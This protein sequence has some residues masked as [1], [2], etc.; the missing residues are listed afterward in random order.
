MFLSYSYDTG[1]IV[2]KQLLT[3]KLDFVFKKLFATNP[4]LLID[5]LNTVLELPDNRQI[6]A[7][8][9]K[10]PTIL[11]EHI[12]EKFIILDILA[13]DDRYRQYDI[14]MQSQKYDAY[15]QRMLFYLAKLYAG[16]LDSGE[17]YD[18]LL[19]VIGVHFLNFAQFSHVDDFHFHFE[20]KDVHHPAL[21]LTGDLALYLFELPKLE[22]MIKTAQWGE[23]MYEWLHFF[24]HAHEEGEQTMQ[25]HYTNPRI[26]KAF[27]VLERL[28]A[29]D[30]TCYLA[31]KRDEAL[32]FEAI[33]L[34][35]AEKKGI[36]T[37]EYIGK[38][39]MLQRVMKLTVSSRDNLLQKSLDDLQQLLEELEKHLTTS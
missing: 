38:I 20:L 17:A 26:R 32:K 31:Q 10:N 15:P 23:N 21:Q 13:I 3:P 39:Q 28:S 33:G 9:V 12:T 14:E 36:E 2:M 29:D 5:L 19:P 1:D 24:N 35:A 7:V 18:T 25:T 6:T 11:A 22:K 27:T 4:E 8:T 16:Q 37:G 30:E 34:A